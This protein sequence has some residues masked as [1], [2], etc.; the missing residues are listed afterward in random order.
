MKCLT[1]LTNWGKKMVAYLKSR[2]LLVR[3]PV[4]RKT[5]GESGLELVAR[6][7][8]GESWLGNLAWTQLRGHFSAAASPLWEA[9]VP[10]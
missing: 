6:I 1:P 5:E 7:L 3:S 4:P 9:S 8:V 2:R 10:F